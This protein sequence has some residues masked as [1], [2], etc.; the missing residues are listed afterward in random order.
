MKYQYKSGKIVT[1][2]ELREFWN[3]CNPHYRHDDVEFAMSVY[4]DIQNGTLKEIEDDATTEREAVK[5][6]E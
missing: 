6:C 5:A 3:R 4:A 1:S 2:E